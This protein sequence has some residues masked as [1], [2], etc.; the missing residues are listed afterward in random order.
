MLDQDFCE[1]LEYEICKAIEL[2]DNVEIK[3]FW[4][5]G[6]LLNQPDS[7]YSQKFVNDNKQV[8]LKA[9]IGKDGQTE[10]E[11]TLK[12][13]NNALS[14]YARNLDIKECVPNPG[15]QN[16]FDIDTKRNKIEVQLD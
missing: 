6:I 11:L 1:F 9:L 13:G 8:L 10:Y 4:C 12:F 14:R 7:S 16:W 15:I 5:D 3:G 2:S